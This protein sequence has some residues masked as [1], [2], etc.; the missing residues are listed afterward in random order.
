MKTLHKT[1]CSSLVGIILLIAPQVA[2][3]DVVT[4]WDA[5]MQSTAVPVGNVFFQTRN[6]A[7]TQLAVFEAVTAI[8]RDYEPY[9]GVI[10]AP[11]AAS[12]EAAAISAA[13]RVLTT[14]Y[15]AAAATLES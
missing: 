3:A 15:P 11:S 12:P 9:T 13:H 14:L 6:A 4:D 10:V 1:L 2:T 7:I 8:V 5:I